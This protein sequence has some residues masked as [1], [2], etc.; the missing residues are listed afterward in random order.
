MKLSTEQMAILSKYE[1]RIGTAVR[2]NWASPVSATELQVIVDIL[3]GVTG[4][5]RRVNANCASCIL[6]ILTDVGRLYFEQKQAVSEA[7]T[8]K[9]GKSSVKAAKVAGVAVKTKKTK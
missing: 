5:N 8:P 4:G 6:E 1:D 7:S 2:S 9:V 3:N